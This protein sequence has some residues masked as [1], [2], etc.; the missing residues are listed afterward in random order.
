[1][2]VIDP[3]VVM[4]YAPATQPIAFVNVTLQRDETANRLVLNFFCLDTN[5]EPISIH[6]KGIPSQVITP[7]QFAAF[8]AM[9]ATAG[10]TFDQDTSRRALPIVKS[11]LGLDG[12]VI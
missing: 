3:P 10:D 11:N 5:K 4:P 6:T 9:P 8:V 7:E 1:M 2:I 12:T